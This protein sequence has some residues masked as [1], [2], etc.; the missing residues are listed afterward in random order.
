[1]KKY[2]IILVMAI[3]LVGCSNNSQA[4]APFEAAVEV[5]AESVLDNSKEQVSNTEET[6]EAG[7][8]DNNQPAVGQGN[9]LELPLG[10]PSDI[11]PIL[12]AANITDTVVDGESFYI[13]FQTNKSVDEVK[14]AYKRLMDGSKLIGED[15]QNGDY[16]TI[17]CNKNNTNIYISATKFSPDITSVAITTTP[18]DATILELGEN[19]EGSS[20]SAPGDGNSG[21]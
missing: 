17:N 15:Y 16:Y 10:F 2:L 13:A 11:V 4:K 8:S 7:E 9:N 18:F 20:G 5:P 12:E 1:M 3:A 19:F 6:A 14:K 21:Q